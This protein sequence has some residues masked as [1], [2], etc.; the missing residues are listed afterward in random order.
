MSVFAEPYDQSVIPV[1]RDCLTCGRDRKAGVLAYGDVGAVARARMDEG[2]GAECFCVAH[3]VA[4]FD[5]VAG[6]NVLGPDAVAPVARA[7]GGDNCVQ[8]FGAATLVVLDD[9]LVALADVDGVDLLRRELSQAAGE[10][11]S[12][13]DLGLCDGRLSTAGHGRG[14]NDGCCEF[15]AA[16]LPFWSDAAGAAPLRASSC[17]LAMV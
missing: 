17:G 1:E 13:V 5:V 6:T 11:V 12:E 16:F 4:P 2:L 7:E 14:R 10:G 8:R 15:H 9:D 3:S